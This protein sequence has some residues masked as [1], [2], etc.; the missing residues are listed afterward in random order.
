MKH[1]LKRCVL[2]RLFEYH[3]CLKTLASFIKIPRSEM[4]AQWTVGTA[5]YFRVVFCLNSLR[6]LVIYSFHEMHGI[7]LWLCVVFTICVFRYCNSWH[8]CLYSY[9]CLFIYLLLSLSFSFF[10]S[11]L[12]PIYIYL[13]S[14]LS[15]SPSFSLNVPV[16]AR[17][18]KSWLELKINC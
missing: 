9:L 5:S 10:F 12:I 4:D 8:I 15:L 11:L 2:F 7:I 13:S 18:L 1:V 16:I 17:L 3:E 14:I 6:T